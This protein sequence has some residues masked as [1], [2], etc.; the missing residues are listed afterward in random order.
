MQ[1]ICIPVFCLSGAAALAYEVLWTRT[2]NFVIGNSVYA[3]TT[4]L[5]VFLTGICLGTLAA[6]SI[7][8]RTAKLIRAL[9]I[10]QLAAVAL[11]VPGFVLG[12]SFPLLLK[13]ATRRL[14][15]LGRR[16]GAG[17]GINTLGGILGSLV[18]G[19]H[20]QQRVGE[21]CGL[22][23]TDR[24]DGAF[25]LSN[26]VIEAP[27]IADGNAEQAWGQAHLTLFVGRDLR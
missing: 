27:R 18:A 5:V 2:L 24:L 23:Q 26:A 17:Y 20:Q 13:T 1:Y 25:Y 14:S 11:L 7:V 21:K 22:A 19:F 9:G 4:I 16:L 12:L 6:G 10:I 3:F 8:D 15:H